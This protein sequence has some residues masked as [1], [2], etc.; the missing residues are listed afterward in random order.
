M[1]VFCATT[2]IMS[3]LFVFRQCMWMLS[4]GDDG[5]MICE[6]SAGTHEAL[7]F[8]GTL[9]NFRSGKFGFSICPFLAK[10]M[11]NFS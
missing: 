10:V 8:A 9:I 4:A 3:W 2:T 7:E 5:N 6:M 1:L 11:R